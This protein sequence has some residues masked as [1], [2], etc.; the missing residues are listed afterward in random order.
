MR[1]GKGRFTFS[2]SND[3]EFLMH[4]V[5]GACYVVDQHGLLEERT[6]L[7]P[8]LAWPYVHLSFV[9]HP[10]NQPAAPPPPPIFCRPSTPCLLLSSICFLFCRPLISS[11]VHPHLLL[12]FRVCISTRAGFKPA[13]MHAL[14]IAHL[15]GSVCTT[16]FLPIITPFMTSHPL[17]GIKEKSKRLH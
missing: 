14:Q 11:V 2:S 9:V 13:L 16:L 6:P 5:Y 10:P 1:V 17:K 15:S 8:T 3:T 4:V 12:P 7:D